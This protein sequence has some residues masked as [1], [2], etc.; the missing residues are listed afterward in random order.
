MAFWTTATEPKRLFR[1]K[2]IIG[3]FEDGA[4]WYAKSVTKPKFE[5]SE[6]THKY[7]GHTFHF[8]GS[9]TWQP[10][11]CTLVDP[12]SPDGMDQLM[13]ILAESGYQVPTRP[14]ASSGNSAFKT[15]GKTNMSP[16]IGEVRISQ[17]DVEGNELEVFVLQNPIITGVDF[18]DL[19]YE[20]DDLS[21]LAITFAYDWCEVTADGNTYFSNQGS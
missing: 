17:L 10:V 1:F 2:V 15:V 13:S 4:I 9:V 8:P 11:T 20:S 14:D 16:A 19:N 5:I 18:G 6:G 21:T 3:N 12:V 7:L